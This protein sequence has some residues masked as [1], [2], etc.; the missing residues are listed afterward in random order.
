MIEQW[1]GFQN[2]VHRFLKRASDKEIC[3]GKS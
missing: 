1:Q 2:L 3:E